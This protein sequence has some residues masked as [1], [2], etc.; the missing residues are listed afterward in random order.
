MGVALSPGWRAASQ[1]ETARLQDSTP[2]VRT[3]VQWLSSSVS[4]LVFVSLIHFQTLEVD[5]LGFWGG[6]L[7]NS[8]FS[9]WNSPI[10]FAL[11]TLGR[12]RCLLGPRS[13]V[14]LFRATVPSFTCLADLPGGGGLE[15]CRP[16]PSNSVF[17]GKTLIKVSEAEKR[18]GAAERDF[19]H[20]A[21]LS[22]LTPLRN[23]LE[24]DW[25]TIS[26]RRLGPLL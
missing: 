8:F 13:P 21:S 10:L 5:V 9:F 14:H 3:R 23:F 22:F 18:L 6:D 25:K 15:A 4:P 20:T 24:G 11:E 12:I 1:E 7:S 16:S 26:V 17:L 2:I 19:I